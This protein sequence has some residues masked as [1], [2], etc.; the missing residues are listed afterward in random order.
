MRNYVLIKDYNPSYRYWIRAHLK[1]KKIMGDREYSLKE[2]QQI[3]MDM[4]A[5]GVK[6]EFFKSYFWAWREHPDHQPDYFDLLR[7]ALPL[8]KD[9]KLDLTAI[10]RLDEDAKKRDQRILLTVEDA[11]KDFYNFYEGI[12]IKPLARDLERGSEGKKLSNYFEWEELKQAPDVT[13]HG[14]EKVEKAVQEIAVELLRRL[15]NMTLEKILDETKQILDYHYDKGLA[16][17]TPGKGY[18]HKS[19][20][21]ELS[22][23]KPEGRDKPV[24]TVLMPARGHRVVKEGYEGVYYPTYYVELAVQ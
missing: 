22:A 1:Q 17:A 11:A 4:A 21:V 24:T 7:L 2:A 15:R 19:E 14:Q 5:R 6:D 3:S 8:E 20:Y 18:Y 12:L 13:I 16:T 10:A 23:H 9:G